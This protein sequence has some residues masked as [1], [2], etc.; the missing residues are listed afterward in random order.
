MANRRQL[1]E[2]GTLRGL[3]AELQA[4]FARD[5]SLPARMGYVEMHFSDVLLSRRMAVVN[6]IAPYVRGRTLEW[7]CH[8]AMDSCIYRMRHGDAVEL[9]GCDIIPPDTYKPFHRFAG[10]SYRELT[11][12]NRLEYADGFFDV[13][14]S[15]GVL[16]HVPDDVAST[17]EIYR[18]L[19]PGGT[20][21]VTCL[22]NRYSYTEAL[23]RRIIGHATHERLYSMASARA[24]LEAAG[25][26]VTRSRYFLMLPTVLNGFPAGVRA[27]YQ[28]ANPA[29][30]AVNA[31]LE[32]ISPLNRLSSN[33]MLIAEK[34]GAGG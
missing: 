21:V 28:K 27:A 1:A 23:Q 26:R 31:V 12:P 29:L 20:F 10:L 3:L 18:I 15:D 13:V 24:M 17:G 34:P 25:F 30:W 33:L 16:E 5:H 7:G 4:E 19:R 14:T 11:H 32:R 9:H 2:I 8:H 6:A 22:P